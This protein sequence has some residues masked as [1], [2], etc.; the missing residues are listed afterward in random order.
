MRYHGLSYR[1]HLG[2]LSHS[3]YMFVAIR[4]ILIPGSILSD[5]NYLKVVELPSPESAF[6]SLGSAAI[7]GS[8]STAG[9]QSWVFSEGTSDY[10]SY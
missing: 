9:D 1:Q 4:I 6:P 3:R 5:G 8:S 10:S 7:K 2:K